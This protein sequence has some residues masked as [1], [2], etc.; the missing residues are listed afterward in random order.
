MGRELCVGAVVP[1]TGRLSLLGDPL[2]F[3]LALL[4]PAVPHVVNGGRRYPLRL[5]SRD[6]RSDPG[7]ARRAVR[8]LVEQEGA[9]VVLTLGGT[10]VLPAVADT[11]EE[12]GVPCV[13]TTFPWQAY[14][15]GRGA[16]PSR[17]FTW[18]YHFAWGLDDIAGVFA[19]MWQLCA[20]RPAPVGCLWNDQ[21]PGRLLR[22]PGR[23][24]LPRAGGRGHRLVDPG[25]YPEPATTFAPHI[26]S[27]LRAGTEIV[28]TAATER[29]L[30][31]FHR[32]AAEHGLRPRLITSSRWLTYPCTASDLSGAGIATL[33]YWSPR[34]PYRSSLD[35]T[36]PALLAETYEQR[37][38]NQWLQPLGLAYALVE[39]AVHALS[40]A[41]DPAD[42]RS[43]ADAIGR[44]RLE[45][46][47]GPLDW[48]GGPTPNVAPIPLVGGQWQPGGRHPAELAIVT[49]TRLPQLRT[50]AGLTFA[51]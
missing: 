19:E 14:V 47:A 17:P 23:G 18:T 45:T 6:S 38:G 36:T 29:D 8:E 33:V 42:R 49:N 4:A 31:L 10:Q 37:T 22:H 5:A 27:F 35:G 32:E 50:D 16:D 12:L 3:V 44:T 13:S 1:C 26:G 40:T 11:C 48:T 28:T 46:I 21:L 7:T 39:V 34:H 25:S 24:F 30:A 51:R 15:Y 20:P 41:G 43:V 9:R 2:S